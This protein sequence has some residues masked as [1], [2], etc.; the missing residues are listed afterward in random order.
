MEEP[1]EEVVEVKAT[2]NYSDKNS[3]DS[4]EDSS[5]SSYSD[6]EGK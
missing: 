6:E 3:L 5:S 4:D 1:K 2:V